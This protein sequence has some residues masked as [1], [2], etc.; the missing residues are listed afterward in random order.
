V[1]T[2]IRAKIGFVSPRIATSSHYNSF[3]ALIPADVRIDFKGL[4][5]AG[6]S[7]YE[8]KGKKETIL[9]STSELSGIHQWQGVIVS[10]APVEV[11]NPGLLDGLRT[12]L[13]VPVTTALVSSVAALRA[14]SAKRVLLMTPF[15]E[16][17][18]KM[19]RDYLAAFGIAAVSPS[20][21]LHNAYS[22]D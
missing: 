1:S 15:D 9:R 14:Y 21:V 6:N 7:L 19:I 13:P 5:L 2:A 16:P 4:E 8:L 10:G 22:V 3:K 20:E 12:S 11:L 17:L 18:N